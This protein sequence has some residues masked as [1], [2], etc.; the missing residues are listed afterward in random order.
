ML[1]VPSGTSAS[2]PNVVIA[3][4]RAHRAALSLLITGGT[5]AMCPVAISDGVATWPVC[6]PPDTSQ[7]RVSRVPT[8]SEVVAGRLATS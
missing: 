5:A 2:S 3:A 7:A 8:P 1:G 4:A 6:A